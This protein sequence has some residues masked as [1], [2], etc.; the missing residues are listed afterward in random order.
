M[1]LPVEGF[2]SII[3]PNWNNLDVIKDCIEHINRNTV[4]TPYEVI[5]VDNGSIDGS[6]EWLQSVRTK[7][8]D[9]WSK[10]TLIQEPS[11]SVAKATNLG[12]SKALGEHVCITCNDIKPQ[13]NW[14]KPLVDTLKAEKALGIVAPQLLNEDLSGQFTG[15]ILS[16]VFTGSNAGYSNLLSDNDLPRICDYVTTTTA[17]TRRSI[18]D[19]LGGFTEFG[20]IFYEDIDFCIRLRHLGYSCA[21]VPQ[22]KVIHLQSKTVSG[23]AKE[24]NL[25]LSGEKFFHRWRPWFN[26]GMKWDM[27]PRYLTTADK[28]NL[29]WVKAGVDK[30]R[31]MVNNRPQDALLNGDEVDLLFTLAKEGGGEGVIVEIGAYKGGSTILLALGSKCVNREKVYSVDPHT[32]YNIAVASP[33]SLDTFQ[34]NIGEAGVED[35]VIPIFKTSEDAHRG[36]DKPIRLLFIDGDHRYEYVRNDFL[37]WEP[38]L[39]PEGVIAFHD[40]TAISS[41]TGPRRVINEYIRNS[42]KFRDVKECVYTTYAVK[43]K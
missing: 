23:E 41:D 2:T 40:S 6:Y 27:S 21:V 30:V 5:V 28:T 42:D 34:K 15:G 16:G 43:V 37:W 26:R 14:L 38:W 20:L 11:L 39:V 32:P 9:T 33:R 18:W 3:V 1:R 10:F 36:W 17:L 31:R 35:W 19:K 7:D 8:K 25:K 13:W 22:S 29:T 12:V 4:G 24:R